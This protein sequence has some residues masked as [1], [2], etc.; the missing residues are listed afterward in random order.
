VVR[1]DM[2]LNSSHNGT[3]FPRNYLT[4]IT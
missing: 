3:E 2:V 1:N 4:N